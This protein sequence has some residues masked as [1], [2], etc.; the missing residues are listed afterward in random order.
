LTSY[1]ALL[2]V[3]GLA[4][5]RRDFVKVIAGSTIGW[6]LTAHAQTPKGMHRIG[7]VM[8]YTEQDPSGQ[9]QVTAFREQLQKLGWV[10]GSNLIIDFR[11]AADDPDR[12]GTLARELLGLGPDV[13]VSNSN[14]VTTVLQSEVRTIPLVFISVS[15]PIGSGFVT[16]LARPT[17]NVTGFANFQP[18]MGGKWLDILRQIAPQVDHAGLLFHPEPPNFGYLKSAEEAAP[19]FNIKLVSLPVQGQADIEK[20]FVTM[21]TQ[22]NPGVVVVPNAVSF[23]NSKLIIELAARYRLPA[24]YPFAFYAKAGGLASYGFDAVAQFQ[25]GAAYVDKLLKGA[26]PTELPVQFPTKFELVLNLTTAK[27]L[28]LNIPASFLSLADDLIE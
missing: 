11:Y 8:G 15:D 10:E 6:P 26:K 24:I 4:M 27:T 18:T 13:M 23:A 5:R 19:S 16:D 9:Q 21:G 12:I 22:S 17:S 14:L 25:Q 3:L 20:A 28:G 7:V 2:G 1:D